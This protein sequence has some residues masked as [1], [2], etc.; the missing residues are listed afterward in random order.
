MLASGTSRGQK[1]FK[2]TG[3]QTVC[4]SLNSS[5]PSH[6]SV[7]SCGRPAGADPQPDPQPAREQWL[8]DHRGLLSGVSA[9]VVVCAIALIVYFWR[10]VRKRRRRAKA[11]EL[12]QRRL[13]ST[14]HSWTTPRLAAQQLATTRAP[15]GGLTLQVRCASLPLLDRPPAAGPY[16][17]FE[18]QPRRIQTPGAQRQVPGSPPAVSR[19]GCV[20]ECAVLANLGP[21]CFAKAAALL[22]I[23]RGHCNCRTPE[24]RCSTTCECAGYGCH[25]L[26]GAQRGNA[27]R[28]PSAAGAR[29]AACG[30]AACALR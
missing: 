18:S 15:S 10:R 19:C 26:A 25:L 5:R 29:A 27:A 3:N 30:Y 28:R 12:S 22:V 14:P 20:D 6:E 8:S 16:L 17:H 2:L 21:R 7:L 23:M 24:V 1:L 13:Q 4:A 9:A 11:A